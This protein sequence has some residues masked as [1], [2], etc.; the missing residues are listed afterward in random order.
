MVINVSV[1]YNVGFTPI[2]YC[3][4]VDYSVLYYSVDPIYASN[5]EE[6]I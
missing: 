4:V 3:V 5:I 6:S 2:L 1:Q